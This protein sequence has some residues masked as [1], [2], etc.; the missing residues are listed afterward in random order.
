MLA[1][2]DCGHYGP[3]PDRGPDNVLCD[4]EIADLDEETREIFLVA[5]NTDGEEAECPCAVDRTCQNCGHDDHGLNECSLSP[6]EVLHIGGVCVRWTL[7]HP[8]SPPKKE[9]EGGE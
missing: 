2:E 9:S 4:V 7:D 3:D 8:Q 1:C 6:D 5:W